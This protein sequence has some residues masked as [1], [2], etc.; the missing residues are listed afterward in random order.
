MAWTIENFH[1]VYA[2]F[3]CSIHPEVMMAVK[4]YFNVSVLPMNLLHLNT[5]HVATEQ[6]C[7]GNTTGLFEK[8]TN[9]SRILEKQFS[10]A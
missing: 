10:V 2:D 8:T 3:T 7:C 6:S 4:L 1:T 5:L 9:A